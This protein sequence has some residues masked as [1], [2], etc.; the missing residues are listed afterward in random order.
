MKTKDI[1]INVYSKPDSSIIKI[2]KHIKNELSD[3]SFSF[4]NIDDPLPPQKVT[5][6]LIIIEETSARDIFNR[7]RDI[8]ESYKY[9]PFY[10]VSSE[11]P[12]YKKAVK[13]MKNDARDYIDSS[14]KYT[15]QEFSEILNDAFAVINRNNMEER[16]DDESF[17]FLPVKI[18]SKYDWDKLENNRQYDMTVLMITIILKEDVSVYTKEDLDNVLKKIEDY[19]SVIISN[20]GGKK[21]FWNYYNG[22]FVFYFGD[23][24]N[25]AVLSAILILNKLKLFI[26]EALS[27]YE[28]FDIKITIHDGG[29]QYFK[30]NTKFI[31]SDTI[32]SAVHL[33][34]HID[35][36]NSLD[37]TENVYESL[38]SRIRKYF[39]EDIL[40]EGRKTY[41]YYYN[42]FNKK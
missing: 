20:L 3:Y 13:W 37:I 22:M 9:A 29:I 26:F 18:S 7:Y 31:T 42:Y 5:G 24:I 32:N 4:F 33:Q 25:S 1:S 8:M 28:M 6:A 34:N 12:D 39:Y 41:T 15:P 27:L 36:L 14:H 23:R 30:K 35:F 11:K 2:I 17:D 19:T 38:N 21:L 40:F 10:I 16:I